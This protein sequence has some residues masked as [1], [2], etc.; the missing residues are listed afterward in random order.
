MFSAIENSSTS[1]RRCRSS[2]MCPMP[3]SSAS[4]GVA[5]S[6]RVSRRRVTLPLSIFC[7]PVSASISSVWPFPST[8]AIPTISPGADVE[9]DAAHLLDSA[10]V[11][12]VKILDLEQHVARL[13]PAPSRRGAAPHA[14]P[15]RARATASVAPSRGT[16]SIVLPRRRTVIRSAISSTSLSLWRDEDDRHPVGLEAADDPE[17]LLRLLRSE[18]RSRLVE[19]EQVGVAVERLEDLDA[20]LLADGD[21]ADERAPDR[22]RARTGPT[23]LG[24][25]PRP[26]SRSGGGRSCGSTPRTMFS[27]T[28]IT[29]MSMKCWCTIPIPDRIASRADEN[30]TG[31]PFSLNLSSVGPVEPVED[32]H[33]RR[34]A[35]AVLAEQR[36]HFAATDVEG[37]LVVGDD[38]RELLADVPHLENEVVGLVFAHRGRK[39]G[40]ARGP[41]SR[42]RTCVSTSAGLLA[43]AAGGLSVSLM[44]FVLYEFISVIHARR[45]LR[46]DLP[47]AD[48]VVLEV[49][50]QVRATLPAG[51]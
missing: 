43:Q 8:P 15:S 10:V 1:P 17:Q 22:P 16:V 29:G 26:L 27:A 11:A 44:I 13:V 47:D 4:R 50:E 40:R 2:G 18:H 48:A 32:V 19:D 36:V 30:E 41:P 28:V 12:D 35:G 25:A 21:V 3:A 24:P 45:D 42:V 6:R 38:A 51:W 5:C 39:R 31:L 49:E 23:A 20:L 9:R 37:D 34:L 14:R 7:R 46:G 33:Q